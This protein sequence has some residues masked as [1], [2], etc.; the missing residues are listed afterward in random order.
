MSRIQI[1]QVKFDKTW[2]NVNLE[3]L[4]QMFGIMFDILVN[5]VLI[6]LLQVCVYKIYACLRSKNY[7]FALVKPRSDQIWEKKRN[8]REVVNSIP[9]SIGKVPKFTYLR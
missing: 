1:K 3:I 5:F 9:G 2:E 7:T 6:W 8:S 4:R